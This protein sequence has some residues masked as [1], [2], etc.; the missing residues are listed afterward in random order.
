MRLILSSK[1]R[2]GAPVTGLGCHVATA[3]VA[4]AEAVTREGT[5]KPGGTTKATFQP[6]VLC[7]A[8][9]CMVRGAF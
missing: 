7:I 2:R 8:L 6:L 1:G 9:S 5:A 4:P 3:I